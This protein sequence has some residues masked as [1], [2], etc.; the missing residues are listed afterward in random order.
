MLLDASESYRRI[1]AEFSEARIPLD[2][3]CSLIWTGVSKQGGYLTRLHV[4][5]GRREPMM[6]ELVNMLAD[7]LHTP[8]NWDKAC[9]AIKKIGMLSPLEVPGV[10][11]EV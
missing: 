2:K 7:W 10:G 3:K 11:K 8:E 5:V 4:S 1:G 6:H 9:V